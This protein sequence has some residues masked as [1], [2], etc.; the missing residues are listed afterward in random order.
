M[1]SIH[2]MR[3]ACF[4]A[5]FG[6]IAAGH[7][8]AGEP[9]PTPAAGNLE[10]TVTKTDESELVSDARVMGKI[11]EV[12]DKTIAEATAASL[13]AHDD[14]V[15]A[16]ATELTDEYRGLRERQNALGISLGFVALKGTRAGSFER[17]VE[18]D[19]LALISQRG[20]GF[21][22]AYLHR[23][24]GEH[25]RAMKLIETRLLP[26]ARQ[27]EVR[28]SIKEDVRPVLRR[29]LEKA[30]SLLAAI[31][32]PGPNATPSVMP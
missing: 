16:F 21:D 20:E 14:R 32:A 7:G 23:V 18:R 4:I 27:D 22:R 25:E 19:V 15:R 10:V 29:N 9:R 13:V 12:G 3:T 8:C 28:A 11:D 24:I 5:A 6:S 17:E 2:A 31:E 30:Q 1:S 26:Q